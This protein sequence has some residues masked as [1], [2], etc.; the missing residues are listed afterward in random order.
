MT[1]FSG[2]VFKIVTHFLVWPFHISGLS[3]TQ[4]NVITSEKRWKM[5]P[6]IKTMTVINTL[7]HTRNIGHNQRC[8]M[9]LSQS[10]KSLRM[11][12]QKRNYCFMW[13]EEE[14]QFDKMWS[15]PISWARP[16]FLVTV[17]IF[18]RLTGDII[19]MEMMNK[20]LWNIN[21][22]VL[23]K[24]MGFKM[25]LEIFAC[26]YHLRELSFVSGGHLL[27]SGRLLQGGGLG[28]F[29]LR[30]GKSCQNLDPPLTKRGKVQPL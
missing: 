9:M 12:D 29:D 22:M 19:Q 28:N 2:Q 20:F 5:N 15:W 24:N 7:G 10:E 30:S 11:N 27:G 26:F 3:S 6:K 1:T 16:E 8:N 13:K 17:T 21:S 18:F 25:S 14:D 23:W 4:Y